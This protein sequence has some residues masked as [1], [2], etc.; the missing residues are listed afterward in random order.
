MPPPAHTKP[1]IRAALGLLLFAASA[2]AGS[3]TAGADIALDSSVRYGGWG[4][5][6]PRGASD[7]DRIGIEELDVGVTVPFIE[8]SRLRCG[9]S[10]SSLSQSELSVHLL[11]GY[12]KLNIEGGVSLGFMNDDP[13]SAMPAVYGGIDAL[14]G[15]RLG[16]SFR[17]ETS[18]FLRQL[19]SLSSPET[20]FDQ[21]LLGLGLFV[22]VKN[23]VIGISCE[24]EGLVSETG[25]SSTSRNRRTRAELGIATD[26]SDFWLNSTTTFGSEIQDFTE[27][28]V[29]DRIVALYVEETLVFVT[30]RLELA[31]GVRCTVSYIPLKDLASLSPP[32][33]PSFSVSTGAR[34]K[35]SKVPARAAH[36]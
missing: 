24:S 28:A 32:P 13:S 34:W 27:G 10:Y 29:H 31:T 26:L 18:V 14:I 22:P 9:Y 4:F 16:I 19:F 11:H 36:F 12:R 1:L 2:A 17:G 6:A 5:K 25:S 33:A 8:S 20:E 3:R 15:R 30:G 21:N 35:S 23:A 7:I